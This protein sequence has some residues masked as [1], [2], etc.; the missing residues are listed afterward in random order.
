MY[1]STYI[2]VCWRGGIVSIP[3]AHLVFLLTKGRWP[4]KGLVID[5]INDDSMD[6]RPCNLQE[7]T[8]SE[9][10][11]K[12]RGRK[13]FRNYGTGKYG[14]GFCVGQ[15]KRSGR[16]DVSRS[17]SRG[18]TKTTKTVKVWYGSH[19]T[20]EEAESIVKHAIDQIEG[21][22][23]NCSDLLDALCNL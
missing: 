14:H 21:R 1:I 16:F 19:D 17:L 5:H 13:V 9:N 10:M 15:D 12:R 3:Y 20:L 11:L 2:N 18:E 6:N 23:D 4:E 8:H 22:I 7:V